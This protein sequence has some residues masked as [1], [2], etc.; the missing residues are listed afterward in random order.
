MEPQRRIP[1]DPRGHACVYSVVEVH[2]L[3]LHFPRCLIARKSG[4]RHRMKLR[5]CCGYS[6]KRVLL[7]RE[8]MT[9]PYLSILN[10]SA[11]PDLHLLEHA[12]EK[13]FWG[14]SKPTSIIQAS[15]TQSQLH[16]LV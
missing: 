5:Q 11:E 6:P 13:E 14:V 2:L 1:E 12:P 3:V 9:F 7:C 8:A 15:S 16:G 4:E 10:S